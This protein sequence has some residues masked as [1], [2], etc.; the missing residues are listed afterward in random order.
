MHEEASSGA[1]P[2]P[3]GVKDNTTKSRACKDGSSSCKGPMVVMSMPT[4]GQAQ[5]GSPLCL[6]SYLFPP[7]ERLGKN[8][9]QH[10][11]TL[12]C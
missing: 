9:L 4:R 10:Q 6:T 1:K 8:P 3:L 7:K 5:E 2:A 11:E 12:I